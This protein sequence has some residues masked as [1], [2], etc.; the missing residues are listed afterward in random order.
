MGYTHTISCSIEFTFESDN[1]NWREALDEHFDHETP[2][3]DLTA[4]E[5]WEWFEEQ[6]P[7]SLEDY[8]T[9]VETKINK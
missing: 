6:A 5:R 1:E 4:A 8:L 3:K 2:F 7:G 9:L